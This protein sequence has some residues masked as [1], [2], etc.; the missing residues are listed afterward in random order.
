VAVTR[1]TREA[2][3]AQRRSAKATTPDSTSP[4]VEDAES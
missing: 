1:A 2:T 4:P 3:A